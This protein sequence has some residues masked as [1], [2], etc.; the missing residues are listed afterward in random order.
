MSNKSKSKNANAAPSGFIRIILFII[1]IFVILLVS[2][3]IFVVRPFKVS[4]TP[5]NPF[6]YGDTVLSE[7]ITYLFN[8]PA[9]GDR[10]IFKPDNPDQDFI[11]VIT[12]IDNPE[13]KAVYTVISTGKGQPWTVSADKITYRI[14]YPPLSNADA[15]KTVLAALPTSIP[16]PIP[17]SLPPQ[18]EEPG[19]W[20]TLQADENQTVYQNFRYGFSFSYPNYLVVNSSSTAKI[21]TFLQKQDDLMAQRLLVA[22]DETTKSLEEVVKNYGSSSST[23][24]YRKLNIAGHEGLA[25]VKNT[26]LKQECNIADIE[27]FQKY[28]I[29]VMRNNNTVITLVPNDACSTMKNNWFSGILSS[30][31]FN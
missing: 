29:V 25:L 26:S 28:E 4:G 12:N 10:V 18:A 11:G 14:Y 16:T 1:V 5:I 22:V 24:E 20:T 27:T 3:Y 15:L 6:K 30:V 23:A 21:T 31:N 7:K 9:L 8:K 2:G 19:G 17:T 13:S